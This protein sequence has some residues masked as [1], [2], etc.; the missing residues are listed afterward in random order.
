MPGYTCS[1]PFLAWAT[2]SCVMSQ[3]LSFVLPLCLS[4]LVLGCGG[5]NKGAPYSPPPSV[6]APSITSHPAATSV[7]WGQSAMFSAPAAGSPPLTYQWEKNGTAIAGAT[8]ASYT[9][10]AT[11]STDS[12]SMYLVVVTNS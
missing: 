10:P 3:R 2:A 12:G 6:T 5:G 1:N 7:T 8:S 11:T 4:V 9:T